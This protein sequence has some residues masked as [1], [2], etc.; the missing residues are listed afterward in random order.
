[1]R[2]PTPSRKSVQTPSRSEG[3][4]Q[5]SPMGWG[6]SGARVQPGLALGGVAPAKPR[7]PWRR[8]TSRKAVATD[9]DLER[10]SPATMVA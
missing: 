8:P 9:A 6:R 3:D 1:M 4:A 7:L 2:W 10:M 5:R